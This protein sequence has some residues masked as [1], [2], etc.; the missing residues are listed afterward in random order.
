[1]LTRRHNTSRLLGAVLVG[2]VLAAGAAAA[3]PPPGAKAIEH[4]ETRVRPLLIAHC[5]KCHGP[6][7]QRGGLRLDSASGVTRGGDSGP[8]VI[9]GKPD[10]SLLIQAVRQT[11]DLKMPPDKKLREQE[12]AD[13]DPGSVNGKAREGTLARFAPV[14]QVKIRL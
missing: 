1:M 4:F 5:Q 11:G 8:P 10:T 6:E 14:A 9:P 13:L 3:A 12:I 7:K 2:F